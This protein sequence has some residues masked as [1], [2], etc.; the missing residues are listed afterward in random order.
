MRPR[1]SD[2]ICSMI[3]ATIDME[4]DVI[5]RAN[6]GSNRHCDDGTHNSGL[7]DFHL[8]CSLLR[9]NS[10]SSM[11]VTTSMT[12]V[13]TLCGIV[14]TFQL[15]DCVTILASVTLADLRVNS[16]EH[17]GQSSTVDISIQGLWAD[18][19]ASTTYGDNVTRRGTVLCILRVPTE[20]LFLARPITSPSRFGRWIQYE[21][22]FS[23]DDDGLTPS[24]IFEYLQPQTIIIDKSDN[25]QD[26]NM[27]KQFV[28]TINADLGGNSFIDLYAS[29][30]DLRLKLVVFG[31]N[32]EERASKFM[33][34]DDTI[35]FIRRLYIS[36]IM[37]TL[38]AIMFSISQARL[39]KST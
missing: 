35:V 18:D 10:N 8:S 33:L 11:S 38:I 28:L 17:I 15:G 4:V 36:Q 27:W 20:I 13:R 24:A 21:I 29:K 30:G 9:D 2:D 5:F 23:N 37:L 32:P 3:S 25:V 1:M 19:D 31:S 7:H 22:T 14:P 12:N 26:M 6:S 39:E 34:F 16:D